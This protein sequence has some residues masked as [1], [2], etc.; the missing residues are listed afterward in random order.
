[1]QLCAPASGTNVALDAKVSAS[2][3]FAG[4]SA[5]RV[6]DG[7]RSTNLGGSSSWANDSQVMPQ[8]LEL[9]FGT[10]RVITRVDVYTT[11]GW[12][13]QDYDLE[14]WNG[15]DFA[16][17]AEVKGSTLA[18]VSSEFSAKPTTKLRLVAWKGPNKQPNHLRVNEIEVYE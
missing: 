18:C 4:Y 9:D 11:A 5:N 6:N 2:S 7:N 8:W 17:L 13:L 16:P 12:E 14:Y 1:M 3:T 10:E 15:G